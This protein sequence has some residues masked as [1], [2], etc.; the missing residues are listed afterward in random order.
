MGVRCSG[1]DGHKD[2][3]LQD[4]SLGS[5]VELIEWIWHQRLCA[6]FAA[7]FWHLSLA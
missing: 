6:A 1:Y 3:A 7:L 2:G 4:L 5:R